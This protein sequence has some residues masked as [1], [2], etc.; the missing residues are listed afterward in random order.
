LADAA[1]L[2]EKEE[3]CEKAIEELEEKMM[4]GEYPDEQ[5]QI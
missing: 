5:I 2:K 4:K 1:Q 3:A